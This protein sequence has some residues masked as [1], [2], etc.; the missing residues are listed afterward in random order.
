MTEEYRRSESMQHAIQ[1]LGRMDIYA[2]EMVGREFHELTHG[3]RIKV[4]A[5]MLRTGVIKKSDIT[6]I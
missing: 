3:Q 5:M 6:Y 1:I 2:D 4:I